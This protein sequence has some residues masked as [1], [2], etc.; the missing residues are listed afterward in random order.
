MFHPIKLG[1]YAIHFALFVHQLSVL[2]LAAATGP[3]LPTVDLGYS[4]YRATALNE[5]GAY[6]N[7]SNIRYAA[8]PTGD[9]RF[10]DPA[11]PLVDRTQVFDG[12]LGHFCPQTP[13]AWILRAFKNLGPDLSL[14][15]TQNTSQTPSEDCLF[16]DVIS[17][18]KV[19]NNAKGGRRN[20]APVLVSIHGGG[21]FQ[22]SKNAHN[23]AGL[24]QRGDNGFI[25]VA[26]NY[27]LSAFGFLSGLEESGANVTSPNAGLLDQRAALKWVRTYIHLFGGDR[28]QVTILG[29]STGG[30]SVQYH[31]TAYGGLEPEE[32]CLF[33][34]AIAQSPNIYIDDPKIKSEAANLFLQAAGATSVDEARKA[35]TEVLQAAIAKAQLSAPFT[36][37][38]FAPS[39]D[40]AFVP[41]L[42]GRLYSEGRY[43]KSL[44]V[45][46]AHVANEVPKPLSD[47]TATTDSDYDNFIKQK[48]PSASPAVQSY[49]INQLYPPIYNGSQPYK[50]PLERITLTIGDLIINCNAYAL[51]RAYKTRGIHSYIFSIPPAVHAQDLAYTFY[52][53]NEKQTIV[54]IALDIQQY[55]VQFIRTGNPN[56][57]G[58]APFPA[59][60]NQ[61]AVLNF[62]TEGVEAAVETAANS[63]C[64]YWLRGAYQPKA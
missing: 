55:L 4:L 43:I 30:G 31:T 18:V 54:P 10:R 28:N 19:F 35:S 24:L 45:L 36:D 5:S 6:Y 8:P 58:L 39:V 3:S 22:G 40:G 46:S 34:Q 41:D 37:L 33:K 2:V 56:R 9:L 49:I 14:F 32:N 23:E 63:R 11:P 17:P 64:D 61:K 26:M 50:T 38:V 21:F 59:Y 42:P 44:N 60:G 62:T 48:F 1:N 16:L 25:F 51:Q 15:A 57:D 7:F 53:D 20:L 52:P 27:R 29:E 13:V 47:P 12:T